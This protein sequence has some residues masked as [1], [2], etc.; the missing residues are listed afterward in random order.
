MKRNTVLLLVAGLSLSFTV[1]AQEVRVGSIKIEHAYTRA[2]VPGQ[3]VA[4]G[5]MKI[6]N[7]GAADQLVAA[8]SPVADEMQLHEMAM[9]GNVMKMREVKAIAIPASGAVELKPGGLHLMF[10]N[11]KAP[12]AAGEIVPVKLR[13]AKAGEVEVKM[14]VNAMGNSGAM[15]H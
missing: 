13:F 7:T 2:T 10:I 1:L 9:E 12:L 15:K 14:P 3:Q 5:F 8:S 4:G 11:I 6:E